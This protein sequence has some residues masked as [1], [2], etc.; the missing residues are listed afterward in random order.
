ME[1]II[2]TMAKRKKPKY[3]KD[4]PVILKFIDNWN[5]NGE[6]V[7]VL[8]QRGAVSIVMPNIQGGGVA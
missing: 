8:I 3:P 1:G 4:S 6:E 7:Q 5:Y 2:N